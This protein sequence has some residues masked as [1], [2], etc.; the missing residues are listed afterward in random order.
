M[1][2]ERSTGE[3]AARSTY[4]P[5]FQQLRHLRDHHIVTLMFNNSRDADI[6]VANEIAELIAENNAKP[7]PEERRTVLGLATGS[8]PVGVYRELIRRHKEEGLDF[9]N[10]VTF[11]LDEYWPMEPDSIH[12]YH[13]WM[14]ENFFDEVNIPPGNIHIPQGNLD[15][16]DIDLYCQQYEEA[17]EAVGGI[18]IQL[19][20]IG[21]TG[22]IGF[23]EPGSTR[24]SRTRLVTLDP[25]TRRDAAASFFGEE[26]VPLQAITMG[27]GTV[28]KA[29]KVIL[30]A[31]GEH[32]APIVREALEGEITP[33]VPASFLQEH[34]N[35]WFILDP[36]AAAELP[37]VKTRWLLRQVKW[38]PEMTKR[39]VIWLSQQCRKPLPKLEEQDFIEHD[40]ADL[41]RARGKPE[42]I[43]EEVFRALQSTITTEPVGRNRKR[44][45]VFSPHPDDDV[46]SMGGTL[47]T[48]ADQGHDVHIAYMTSGCIAV[49]D[50]DVLRHIDFVEELLQRYAADTQAASELIAK[51][52]RDIAQK[53]PGEVDSPEVQFIKG[54]IRKTEA[55]AAAAVAGVP[56][57]KLHFLD[58]PFYRTGEVKKRPIGPEDVRIVRELLESVRPDAI[59]V[60]GDL[61]DPHGTHRLCA[62]AI[63]RALDELSGAKPEVWLYRGAWQEY[64]PHE[65]DMAVPLS[66]ELMQRKE[67]AIF[68]HESQKDRARFPGHDAREFWVRAKERTQMTA[69]LFD[70]LG[71]PEYAGL[72]GF[73]RYRGQL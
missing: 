23:N 5:P 69:R 52:R 54:L 66:P 7:N 1:S 15:P 16:E 62:E 12:S 58:L 28:L 17:I 34:P 50:I 40:L 26:N 27:V 22:H 14:H 13:R 10:V 35:T 37:D 21:R 51:V 3:S 41:L 39:A 46:I 4:I 36:A 59:F 24:N 42:T 20:G 9:S 49:F 30:M 44:V 25:V 8:T 55:I 32:K 72:E 45:I 61:S 29:R 19:L 67:Q 11:N 57:E 2:S 65:I 31:F 68:K 6:W 33:R 60:A 38:T 71:L 70:E 64:E 53:K 47:I 43:R 73:A 48:M 18:D 63:L 56:R